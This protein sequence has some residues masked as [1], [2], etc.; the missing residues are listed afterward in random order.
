MAEWL[1][2]DFDSG[3]VGAWADAVN[4]GGELDNAEG[5][6]EEWHSVVG[7]E[8]YIEAGDADGMPDTSDKYWAD[9]AEATQEA[10]DVLLDKWTTGE[11]IYAVDVCVICWWL[12]LAG[13]G[14]RVPDLSKR[15]GGQ[16]GKYKGH[17]RRKLGID[18]LAS[19]RLSTLTAPCSNKHTGVRVDHKMPV[20]NPYE[21]INLE[22]AEDERTR[23]ALRPVMRTACPI[24][25]ISI[26]QTP[27]KQRK[28]PLTCFST[29]GQRVN[30]S[31]P[32]TCVLYV[33]G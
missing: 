1:D 6:D 22:V 33:G 27:R 32:L 26:G 28:R 19:A 10:L 30:A 4:L 14:G 3:P 13:L 11:R 8:E 5:D 24:R 29:N 25:L 21:A 12:K 2:P 16:P 23:S 15:P 31:T 17:L 20:S 18:K 9:P 7:D